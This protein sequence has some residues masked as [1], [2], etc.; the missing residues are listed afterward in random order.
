MNKEEM[1]KTSSAIDVAIGNVDW[2]KFAVEC[3]TKLKDSK[4][5]DFHWFL[6]MLAHAKVGSLLQKEGFK[7]P[8]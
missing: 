4:D 5:D 2:Q 7:F 1:L 3:A 6:Y 8:F